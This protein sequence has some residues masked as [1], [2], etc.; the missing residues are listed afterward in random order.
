MRK[1]I[2]AGPEK[3]TCLEL[4]LSHVPMADLP[5]CPGEILV[6][7]AEQ[8]SWPGSSGVIPWTRARVSFETGSPVD[9]RETPGVHIER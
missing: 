2:A 8:V 7:I 6:Q 5:G 1:K 3:W 4:P 9:A